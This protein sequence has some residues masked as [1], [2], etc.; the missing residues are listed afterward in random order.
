MLG[1]FLVHAFL[2][3]SEPSN[4]VASGTNPKP[5]Y[6][7]LIRQIRQKGK[8]RFKKQSMLNFRKKTKHFL[9]HDTHRY[10]YVSAAK[11]CLVFFSEN[12]TCFVFLK[13]PYL[14]SP[15]F[16]ITHKLKWYSFNH[17]FHHFGGDKCKFQLIFRELGIILV[18]FSCY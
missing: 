2:S 11:K 15:L 12:L 18:V 1:F 16:L 3:G 10:V 7:N 13:Y 4:W 17:N 14:D 8:S 6:E 5:G 9:P